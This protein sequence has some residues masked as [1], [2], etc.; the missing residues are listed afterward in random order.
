AVARA[1]GRWRRQLRVL[2]HKARAHDAAAAVLEIVAREMP[3]NLSRHRSLPCLKA[4]PARRAAPH[5]CYTVRNSAESDL[6]SH[7]ACRKTKTGA[8]SRNSPHRAA[9]A[10]A[11]SASPR[12]LALETP[13]S[14]AAAS[15][16]AK[17]KADRHEASASQVSPSRRRQRRRG[18][19]SGVAARG[20]GARLSGAPG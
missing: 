10:R 19:P 2:R 14:Q 8:A 11:S 20:R 6:A 5:E 12:R 16:R 1:F 9:A 18:A 17:P 13:A 7:L 15:S 4:E 3:L